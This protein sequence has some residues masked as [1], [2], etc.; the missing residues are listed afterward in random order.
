MRGI[1]GRPTL[2]S[3]AIAVLAISVE[4]ANAQ[5][6]AA[7]SPVVQ[8]PWWLAALLFFMLIVACATLLA[9]RARMAR[10]SGRM[11]ETE[12][13]L[14]TLLDTVNA[15]IYIKDAQ[16]RYT[17]AN[18]EYC[19]RMQITA[20][21]FVGTSDS[22]HFPPDVFQ[23][24]RNVDLRVIEQGK[25]LV[26]EEEV[27]SKSGEGLET[28]L[29]IK[30]PIKDAD[31][32][33]IGLCGVSTDITELLES[34]AA[35]HR[36]AYYDPLTELP[37]RRMLQER[38]EEALRACKR[39]GQIAGLLFIDL[40]KFKNIN[41]ERGHD[42]GDAVLCATGARLEKEIG[43]LG[44]VGRL[45]GDEFVILLNDLGTSRA[46]ATHRALATAERVRRSL[47]EEVQIGDQLYFTGG[48]I[49]VTL[50]DADTKTAM[51]ALR[52]ADTAMYHSKERGRNRVAL[53]E[54]SMHAHIS[55][56]ARLLRDL[57]QA[58]R[59]SQFRLFVQPQYG[60]DNE[61]VGA[62]LL[63]R[64]E[65]P[66]RGVLTPEAFIRLAEESGFVI[67]MGEWV[68][69]QACMLHARLARAG[70]AH[71]LSVNVSPVQLR[72]P[73][74]TERLKE[75]MSEWK[76]PPGELTLEITEDVLI[77]NLEDTAAHM[78]ELSGLGLNFSIDDFGM[79][80]SGL[81]YLHRLPLAEL[82]IPKTFVDKL[83]DEGAATLIRLI[84]S[85]ARLLKLRVVA[86]GV[87]HAEDEEFLLAAGCD[88]LQGYYRQPPLPTDDWA[89]VRQESAQRC[90][91]PH[92]DD[93]AHHEAAGRP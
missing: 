38:I 78:L 63:L 55:E 22:E 19:D 23:R 91:E 26:C 90:V 47:E 27:P 64:W 56:R 40:D 15:C 12:A 9:M 48:S 82:K 88:A 39:L 30:T 86:E 4:A 52:E 18:R 10:Q 20:A 14:T 61:V 53:Y 74:F 42:V 8:L 5:V 71:P 81:A 6:P 73:R 11:R 28:F 77:E 35:V 92:H 1:T 45:G 33:I 7:S 13:R 85:T 79:G 62:E 75:I 57:S 83:P 65:H 29:S 80:Y 3:T 51:D 49:G 37:N 16:L 25:Q 41:D 58:I 84:V 17:Y 93:E 87:E 34:R 59:K 36:L 46:A 60:L 21:A 24:I 72:S 50:L 54:P 69:T 70:L 66:D 43:G 32:R 76:M 44:T 67:E 89:R 2:I 68:L 31:G